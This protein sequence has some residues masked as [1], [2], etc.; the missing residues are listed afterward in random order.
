MKF[1]YP[2]RFQ[3]TGPKEVVV[4]FRDLP[5]CLTSGGDDAEALS[6]AQDALEE[7][8]EVRPRNEDDVYT[9]LLDPSKTNSDFDWSAGFP[10][11]DGIGK[12]TGVAVSEKQTIAD[13]LGQKLPIEGGCHPMIPTVEEGFRSREQEIAIP[14][15]DWAERGAPISA[16]A[17]KLFR[18]S[19]LSFSHR[20]Q[21]FPR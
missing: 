12:E 21:F 15:S 19:A 17:R 6:E 14:R 3:R 18:V 10:L 4:S 1:V 9:I 2:A 7:A 16:I 11:A 20:L 5:E 8:V 13:S